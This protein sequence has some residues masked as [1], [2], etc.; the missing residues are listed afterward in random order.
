M[1]YLAELDVKIQMIGEIIAWN[2]YKLWTNILKL[3]NVE[4]K[5]EAHGEQHIRKL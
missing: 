3:Y 1:I 2:S 4:H 5:S